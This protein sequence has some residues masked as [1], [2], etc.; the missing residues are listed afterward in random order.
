MTETTVKTPCRLTPGSMEYCPF[1]SSRPLLPHI[2]RRR[3]YPWLQSHCSV[4]TAEAIAVEQMSGPTDF[5]LCWML[6]R[7]KTKMARWKRMIRLYWYMNGQPACPTALAQ[8]CVPVRPYQE[9]EETA[10]QRSKSSSKPLSGLRLAKVVKI[11]CPDLLKKT[12]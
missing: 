2:H 10:W 11:H 9:P 3:D 12:I 8:P 7:T 6:A 5:C 4:L 1:S